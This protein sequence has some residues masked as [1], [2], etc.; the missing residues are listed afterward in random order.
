MEDK[1][2]VAWFK[3]YGVAYLVIATGLLIAA[4][5]IFNM[6]CSACR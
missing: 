3:Y 2:W 6:I 5:N 4:V 1:D